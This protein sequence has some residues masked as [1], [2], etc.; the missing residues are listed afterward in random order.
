MHLDVSDTI[1]AIASAPGGG[2]RGIVR[3]SGP[4]A[5]ATLAGGFVASESEASHPLDWAALRGPRRIAGFWRLSPP[6]DEIPCAAY[7]WP[8]SRSY[9][10]Q[11]SVEIH[12]YG[13]PP[14]LQA[15]LSSV[16]AAGA[17]IAGLGEFTLRAFLAGRLDLTQ[18]E[19]VLGVIDAEGD[20]QLR[21]ALAQL[22]GGLATPLHTLRERL[23]DLLAHLEAGLDFVEEDIE[24]ITAAELDSQLQSITRQ[25][26]ELASQ[27][28]TRD[29]HQGEYRIVLYGRPNVGKSSLL[30]ALAGEAAAIVSDTAGT[31][32]DYVTCQVE[33]GGLRCQLIDTAGQGGA[34]HAIDTAA[35]ASGLQQA[36]RAH[37]AILCLDL[38]CDLSAWERQ[39]LEKHNAQRLVV[40]TKADLVG[41]AAYP[42]LPLNTRAIAVSNTTRRGLAE[43]RLAI[44]NRLE[45]LAT[46]ETRCVAGTAARCH[47]SLRLAGE[48]AERARHIAVASHGEELVAAEL[49]VALDELGRV[50]GA[51]YTDDVLD[52]IFSRF[53]IGK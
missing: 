17:R 26:H 23:L 39:E 48:A 13:S 41:S 9:T 14:I 53:C 29:A 22:A 12:T 33:I 8:T 2:L 37:L 46:T 49:R 51:V 15:V 47:E 44:G 45:A 52:R 27:M 5:I 30:N 10:R 21:V 20:E 28:E 3:I 50:V 25:I 38:T 40:L 11:P 36:A 24:F 34:Q 4:D 18:A 6:L 32:R 16:C 7:I 19:A 31:T 1:A 35:E 42:T 43:L